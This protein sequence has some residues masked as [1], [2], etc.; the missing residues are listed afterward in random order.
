MQPRMRTRSVGQSA[1]KSLGGERVYGLVE[2][3]GVED[4]GK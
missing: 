4:L 2:D 3:G 1:I